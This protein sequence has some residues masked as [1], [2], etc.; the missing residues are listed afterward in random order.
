M[1]E[2]QEGHIDYFDG[3]WQVMSNPFWWPEQWVIWFAHRDDQVA[4]L[5]AW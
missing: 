1:R 2:A 5:V 3:D 4:Y